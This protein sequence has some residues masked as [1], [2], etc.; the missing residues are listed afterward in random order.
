M[1]KGLSR[2]VRDLKPSPTLA[3]NAKAKALR[4]KGVDLVNLSAGEPDFDTPEFIKEAACKAIEEGFTRYTPVPGI[5]ELREAIAQKIKAHY[6][7][8][9]TPDSVLVTSGGKQAI[10]NAVAALVEE[11]DEV[12][13]L[14]PYWVSYPPIVEICG[15]R[16][17][18]VNTSEEKG[19]EPSLSAVAEA[20]SPRTKMIIINSPSN[21]TGVVLSPEFLKGVA[22]LAL[23]H[24]F[25]ILTDDIYDLIRFDGRA[26]FNVVSLEP[27]VMDRTL[28]V[29]G[30]SKTYAMTGWRLGWLVGP[31]ELVKA[32]SR[33]Q[34]QSTSNACSISQKAALAALLG[35]QD[36]LKEMVKV[37]R[38]RRDLMV[39]LLLEIPEISCLV[40]MG[41]FYMFPNF[42]AYY[43]RQAGGQV[44]DGSLAM[45]DYLLEEARVACVPGVAFGED[46]CIRLSFATSEEEIEKG[47]TRIK[48]ALAKLS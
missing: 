18:V 43:G 19:F 3:V 47:I 22:H 35:P 42:S 16:P 6:G 44:I 46:T 8:S 2:R 5:P 28:I 23:E 17:V 40:P 12:I 37:F 20:V 26:P 32:A 11:E 30:V 41:S 4:A 7:L 45:A 39:S 13:I 15:G 9:Y 10:F 48:E 36:S 21:P 1:K 34:S 24:D 14:S 29:N 31:E 25:Y 38:R 33:I 27:K